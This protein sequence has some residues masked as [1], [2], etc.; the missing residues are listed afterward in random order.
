MVEYPYNVK[1]K[2]SSPPAWLLARIMPSQS[3]M[4]TWLPVQSAAW[5][6]GQQCW[7]D[8]KGTTHLER[9]GVPIGR[10]V[11][12]LQ[13]MSDS[14]TRRMVHQTLPLP[15]RTWLLVLAGTVHR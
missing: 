11:I 3:P 10:R 15:I 14:V 4:G 7:S 8:Q 1:E 12:D 5:T 9:V 2:S 13:M 6:A